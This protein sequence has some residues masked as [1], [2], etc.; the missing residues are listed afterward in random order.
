MATHED[1]RLARLRALAKSGVS[2][3]FVIGSG[4][5]VFVI[6][7]PTM[8]PTNGTGAGVPDRSKTGVLVG[9][10]S[11]VGTRWAYYRSGAIWETQQEAAAALFDQ[12]VA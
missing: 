12:V 6:A 7:Y 2:L 10:I 4:L 11:R 1:D 5:R 3:D 9:T 8:W